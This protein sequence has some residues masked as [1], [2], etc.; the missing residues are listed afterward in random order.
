MRP[1]E[2][3]ENHENLCELYRWLEQRCDQPTGDDIARFLEKP[4]KWTPEWNEM[5]S[6]LAAAA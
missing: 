4:W 5:Q 2:W 6:E 3:Y 1:R